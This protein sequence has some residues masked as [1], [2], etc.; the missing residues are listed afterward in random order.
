MTLVEA[1]LSVT[2]PVALAVVIDL[3]PVEEDTEL[4]TGELIDVATLETSSTEDVVASE[5]MVGLA[6]VV[7]E[8]C[9]EIVDAPD[10]VLGPTEVCAKVCSIV[11]LVDAMLSVTTPVPPKG[12]V[13][14]DAKL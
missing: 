10:M 3:G 5:V 9:A 4:C 14:E 13:E 12:P 8:L 1:M 6:C 2:R 7:D 11:I